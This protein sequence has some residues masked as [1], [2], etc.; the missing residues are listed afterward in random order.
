[1]S[2]VSRRLGWAKDAATKAIVDMT[3]D[4]A[5]GREPDVNG[6]AHVI[7]DLN[8]R[9][10]ELTDVL[11]AQRDERGAEVLRLLDELA[12]AKREKR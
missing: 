11:C 10:D 1:M 3:R 9:W 12:E 5:N 8:K 6:M 7:D 4:V 2:E